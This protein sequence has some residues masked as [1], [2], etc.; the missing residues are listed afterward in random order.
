MKVALY[1]R[2][3]TERQ[4]K[5]ETIASQLAALRKHA[6]QH[7]Y[8]IAEEFV[9]LDDGVSGARLDR[10]GLDRLRDGAQAA[11]FDAVL[12]HSP[13]RLSRKYAYLI[14][15]IEELERLGVHVLFVEQPLIDDPHA[16]LLVQI[17]GAVA[18][19]ERAKLAERYRRGKL[20]RARQGEVFWHSIPFGYRRIPRQDMHA[21][22]VVIHEPE[23]AIIRKVFDWHVHDGLTIRKI[24]KRLTKSGFRP[25]RG[26]R[27]W[28]ETTVHRILHN[29]A[30]IGTLYYNRV[31]TV[32]VVPTPNGSM[33]RISATRV[34]ER[35]RSEWISVSVPP[36]ID[37]EVFECS[38]ARHE[39]NQQFS[40]RRLHEERWLLRRML[41]CRQCG[42][43][44]ACVFAYTRRAS[45][46]TVA[47]YR[48]GKQDDPTE[49][50]CYPSHVRAAVLDDVVWQELREKLLDPRLLLRAHGQIHGS[51]SSDA[52]LLEQQIHGAQRRLSQSQMER[53]RLIDA[54]QGG[55]V[56]KRDFEERARR[57]AVRVKELEVDIEK[58]NNERQAMLGGQQLLGRMEG[59]T[60]TVAANLDGMSFHE[61]QALVRKVLE[62]V[63][64]DRGHIRLYFKIPLP[65]GDKNPPCPNG[66]SNVARRGTR[67]HSRQP[68]LQLTPPIAALSSRLSL[69]S[70]G[71]CRWCL[72]ARCQR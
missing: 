49:R 17:Q 18:E 6:E 69:R 65:C 48:C 23:A 32:S 4:E 37:R 9:C 70:C 3:S 28:G 13:D 43:K 25:P 59:F 64:L 33:Q 27:R 47:Y 11:C 5:R 12:V 71:G 63:V 54:Y 44:H 50:R 51:R 15:I 34:V 16:A 62:E 72:C 41:R 24:A 21:A 22:H 42:R 57:L 10:A 58:L 46:S 7:G 40:P 56:D 31:H 30:Y 36:V 20:H 8:S 1:A 35:P 26:G 67:S 68:R 45:K 66:E 2:V 29:E 53:G 61:R 19:Y 39:P 55:F 38:Q 60:R 14:L 52:T